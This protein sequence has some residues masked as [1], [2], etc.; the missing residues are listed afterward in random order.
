MDYYNQGIGELS[1][2]F[3]HHQ[4]HPHL[5]SWVTTSS[6]T[7][8]VGDRGDQIRLSCDGEPLGMETVVGSC[9]V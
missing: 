9:S 1:L 4:N 5:K 8:G 7:G 2:D 3:I 6:P